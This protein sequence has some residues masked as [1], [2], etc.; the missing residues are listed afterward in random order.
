MNIPP[1]NLEMDRIFSQ[2]LSNNLRSLAVTAANPRE[3]ATS[4]ALALAQRC[5]LAGHSTLLVDLNLHHP[6]LEE[7]LD[8]RDNE[9]LPLLNKPGLVSTSNQ[10]IAVPGI[11]IP[12]RREAVLKL[13]KPKTLEQCIDQ[14]HQR[15]D[16]VIFDTSAVNRVNA[17]N[18][19]AERVA[20]ACDG[21]LLVVLA[22]VTTETMISTAVEKLAASGAHLV[23]SVINDRQN[24]ILKKELLR[25]TKRMSRRFKRVSDWLEKRILQTPLLSLEI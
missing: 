10:E 6:A 24:P 9:K 1:M 4:V 12:S 15:F 8:L 2:V 5:L 13:R 14:L 3:G 23:G 17:N 25:E 19:P 22:G 21:S 7:T 18:I 11:T 20:A 16:L